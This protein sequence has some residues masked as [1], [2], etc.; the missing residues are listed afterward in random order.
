MGN[1]HGEWRRGGGQP[2]TRCCRSHTVTFQSLRQNKERKN[3]FLAAALCCYK[4]QM[5]VLAAHPAQNTAQLCAPPLWKAPI[6]CPWGLHNISYQA[7]LLILFSLFG[8]KGGVEREEDSTIHEQ[9][10][11]CGTKCA[12]ASSFCCESL[13]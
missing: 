3:P 4:R 8:G 6:T 11:I 1:T 7:S 9:Q 13:A 10:R 2:V 12:T 5:L